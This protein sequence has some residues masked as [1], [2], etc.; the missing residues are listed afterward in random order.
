MPRPPRFDIAGVPQHITQRG[1]D[2]QPCF[3][4]EA[5]YRCYLTH[6]LEGSRRFQCAIHAYVL[7]TN[8]VHLLI[9]PSTAGSLARMMQTLGRRY[10]SYVNGTYQRSGTLWESRYKACLVDTEDYL[11]TCYRYIELNPVR[12]AM[13]DDPSHHPWSSYHTNALGHSNPMIETHPQYDALGGTPIE[14]Q[15]AY[16]YLFKTAIGE[17]RLTEI[18]AYIRQQKAL[19][20]PKFQ[21]HIET[22]LNRCA[23]T[24]PAHRPRKTMIP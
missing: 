13:V 16:Q 2:R 9:T 21:A 11:L 23:Q 15:Q 18:R 10:V 14:R 17:D 8:H 1:H 4:S 6:I 22:M 19:G 5:D 7:M 3:F 12:A 24:R 20:S